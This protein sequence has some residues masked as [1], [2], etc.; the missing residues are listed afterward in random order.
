MSINNADISLERGSGFQ[1]NINIPYITG[2]KNSGLFWPRGSLGD[3][4][5]ICTITRYSPDS[6]NKEN[7]IHDSTGTVIHGH[8]DGK[9]GYVQYGDNF[10][11]SDFSAAGGGGP[12]GDDWLVCCAKTSSTNDSPSNVLLNGNPTGTTSSPGV[13][14]N[15]SNYLIINNNN[16]ATLNSDFDLAYAVIWDKELSTSDMKIVSD[17]LVN[18]MNS[19]VIGFFSVKNSN[20]IIEGMELLPDNHK[21]LDQSS[22]PGIVQRQEFINNAITDENQRATEKFNSV[23]YALSGQERDII[24]NESYRL[25]YMAYTNILIAVIVAII[26]YLALINIQPFIFGFTIFMIIGAGLFILLGC[27]AYICFIIYTIYSRDS[28][29][30][31]KITLDPPKMGSGVS[32]DIGSTTPYIPSNG[33]CCNVGTVW[34]PTVGKCQEISSS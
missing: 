20:A 14:G 24:L 11:L 29:D 5:T 6:R 13:S 17:A 9:A 15:G 8:Q 30:F 19:G 10:V 31:N 34:N 4:F 28:V 3:Q 25:K 26:V 1:K 33:D 12:K 16:D 32:G 2:T 23:K 22:I 18:Y 27:I 21:K 7:I